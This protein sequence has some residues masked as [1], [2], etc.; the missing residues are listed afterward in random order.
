MNEEKFTGKAGDY[1]ATRPSYPKELTDFLYEK[2]VTENS[3]IADVGAGTG[4]FTKL[5]LERGS[6]V[7]CVEPNP[8]MMKKAKELLCGY[9]RFIPVS[10][11]AE[12]TTL[13]DRSVDFITAAQS[14][15]WFDK[16]RFAKECRRISKGKALCALIWNSYD[17]SDV[18]V[19][20]LE[21][22]NFENLS[23]FKG[24]AGG[25]APEKGVDGFFEKYETTTFT[26]RLIYDLDAFV[27]RCFSSS[28]SPER[29]S[30][31]G[32]AYASALTRFFDKHARGGIL[33]LPLVTI[34]HAGKV[35]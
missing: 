18:A 24:F 13:P 32:A 4:K 12:N 9:G 31:T 20:E 28:Y 15:H 11:S 23:R 29:Q 26:S 2:Y 27:G 21:R 33:T 7:Y 10:A 1:A 16:E 19:K 22:L 35:L 3:V 25:S 30:E 34:C 6:T 14:F 17:A 5:L 8:D